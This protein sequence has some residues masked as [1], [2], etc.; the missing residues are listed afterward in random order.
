MRSTSS[1][2]HSE[3]GLASQNSLAAKAQE[4]IALRP[5]GIPSATRMASRRVSMG[6]RRPS[7]YSGSTAESPG[8]GL[9]HLMKYPTAFHWPSSSTTVSVSIASDLTRNEVWN[10]KTT[11][12]PSGAPGKV[13]VVVVLNTFLEIRPPSGSRTC[14][15]ISV[16]RG[17]VTLDRKNEADCV[18]LSE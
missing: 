8:T 5:A 18:Q 6:L 14:L 16:Q 10:R 2:L 7:P 11:Y 4:G 17:C 13:L 12:S 9:T 1:E 3:D 15:T